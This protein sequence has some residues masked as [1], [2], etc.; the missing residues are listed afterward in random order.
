MPD[1][2]ENDRLQPRRAQLL[3]NFLRQFNHIVAQA[4]RAERAEISEVFAELRGL[5]AGGLGER[6]AT[7]RAD[8]VL[9]EPREAAQINR[10]T[11]NRFARDDGLPGFF[12]ARRN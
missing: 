12:Q 3:G 5:D 11:I 10:E 7:H 6:L 8:A 9:L 2:Y 4:A 1:A